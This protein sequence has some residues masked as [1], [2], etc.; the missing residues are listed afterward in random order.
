MKTRSFVIDMLLPLLRSQQI[1]PVQGIRDDLELSHH[2]FA[3][4]LESVFARVV[5]ISASGTFP[6]SYIHRRFATR[7]FV[8]V[9]NLQIRR[10]LHQLNV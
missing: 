3:L 10:C 8:F 7:L 4:R 1:R 5:M 6:A 9:H 2:S